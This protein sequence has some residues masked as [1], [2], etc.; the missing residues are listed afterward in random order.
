MGR[1]L[2]AGMHLATGKGAGGDARVPAAP[3]PVQLPA[4]SLC[5]ALLSQ[6]KCK[7]PSSGKQ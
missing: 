4:T 3:A 5:S 7:A 1:V 6:Q 2:A